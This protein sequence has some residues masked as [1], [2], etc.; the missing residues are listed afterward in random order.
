[1]E[2]VLCCYTLVVVEQGAAYAT[3][4]LR[5][6]WEEQPLMEE[7]HSAMEEEH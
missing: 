2:E 1:M 4:E 7:E 6:D 3:M 5:I